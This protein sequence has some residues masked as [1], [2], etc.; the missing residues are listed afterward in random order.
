MDWTKIVCIILNILVALIVFAIIS[1]M[2]YEMNIQ[3]KQIR[4]IKKTIE[5]FQ[6]AD[7]KNLLKNA[8]ENSEKNSENECKK[9]SD[10]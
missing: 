3:D 10:L 8:D 1:I 6:K 4:K 2:T 9:Q 7:A 5:D